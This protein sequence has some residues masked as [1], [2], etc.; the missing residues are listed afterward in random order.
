M[1][2]TCEKIHSLSTQLFRESYKI[3]LTV[4]LVL[5]NRIAEVDHPDG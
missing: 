2:A 3:V 5:Y 4:I 1:S